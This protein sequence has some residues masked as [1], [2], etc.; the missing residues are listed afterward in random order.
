M[1]VFGIRELSIIATPPQERVPI[2]S[3]IIPYDSYIIREAINR[4][5]NRGGQVYCIVPRIS[6]IK[7]FETKIRN[8]VQNIRIDIVHGSMKS[9][10]IENSMLSLYVGRTQILIATSIIENGLDIQ[11]ANTIIVY[12]AEMFGLGQLY[13]FKGRVGRS[14]KRA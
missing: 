3:F 4:E 8:I 14:N 1:A 13:Q 12:K 7:P 11:K 2:R 10:D 5:L 6:D 9:Q